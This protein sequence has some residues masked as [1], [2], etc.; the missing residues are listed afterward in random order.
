MADDQHLELP[1]G[2]QVTVPEHV[3]HRTFE[4]E[5][6]L[7]NLETGNYHGL[8]PTAGRMFDLLDKMGSAE[9]VV[10]VLA[11]ELDQPRDVIAGDLAHLCDDLTERGLLVVHAPSS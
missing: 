7:L 9:E 11:E 3:V 8:N 10:R 5:T 4:A 2:T 1:P 6:V